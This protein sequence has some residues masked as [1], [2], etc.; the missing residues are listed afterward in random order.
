M[1]GCRLSPSALPQVP[2]IRP[3]PLVITA[4]NWEAARPKL[5]AADPRDFCTVCQR[6]DTFNS[7]EKNGTFGTK[8][9]ADELVAEELG[10]AVLCACLVFFH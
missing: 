9:K 2:S 10:Q 1:Q 8:R 5:R 4:K 6:G 3:S 7:S